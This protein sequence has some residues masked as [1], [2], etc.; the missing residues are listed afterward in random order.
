MRVLRTVGAA[1]LSKGVI[2]RGWYAVLT[3]IAMLY[4]ALSIASAAETDPAA[5]FVVL[6]LAVAGLW[7]IER[8][9]RLEFRRS[10]D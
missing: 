2:S 6:A 3:G 4:A 7:S 8:G 1:L 5:P 10:Q 9:W